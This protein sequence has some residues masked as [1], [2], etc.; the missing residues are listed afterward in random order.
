MWKNW[1]LAVRGEWQG[2]IPLQQQS[3]ELHVLSSS[4]GFSNF[5]V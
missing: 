5:A 4:A 1:L 2:E 3:S